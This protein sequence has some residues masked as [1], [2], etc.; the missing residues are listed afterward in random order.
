MKNYEY[1]KLSHVLERLDAICGIC[2]V[3]EPERALGALQSTYSMVP[4]IFDSPDTYAYRAAAEL[5]VFDVHRTFLE[6]LSEET[7]SH[8]QDITELLS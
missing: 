7:R 5:A 8:Y 4:V 6:A 3:S 1:S 2:F